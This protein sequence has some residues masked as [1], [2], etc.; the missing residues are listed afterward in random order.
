MSATSLDARTAPRAAERSFYDRL[1]AAIPV[2]VVGI[3]IF[4]LYAVEAWLRKTPWLF[5]DEAEWT[6]ISRAIATTG[7]AARRGQ[8]IY[9]KSLYAYLIAPVWWIHSTS[10]AYAVIKYINLI[11]MTSA[12]IPTYLLARMLV[13]KRT[14]FIVAVLAVLIPGMSYSSSIV[15][16]VLAYPWYALCSWLIVRALVS[17]RRLDLA[18]AIGASIVSGFVRWP[19][20]A[21]VGIAFAIAAGVL[22][23]I[24]PRGQAMRAN[25]SKR[26]YAGAIA[27]FYG[28]LILFNRIVLQHEPIWQL[29]TQYSKG[30]MVSLGFQA[31]LSLT[32]GLGLL[33]VIGGFAALRIKERERASDRRNASS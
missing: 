16:E 24:G 19:Q 26:D 17:K 4:I 14:A 21:T 1:L 29:S 22:W 13:T 32:V 15:I 5:S 6:Q 30:R 28:A 11:V 25:W 33:P 7:H 20:F 9:F 3:S 12:A 18:Y 27:L 31:A 23:Y 8:P 2:L 10:T